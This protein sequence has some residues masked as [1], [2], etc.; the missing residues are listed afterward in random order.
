[1]KPLPPVLKSMNLLGF[2]YCYRSLGCEGDRVELRDLIPSKAV[3]ESMELQMSAERRW[4]D[5]WLLWA[6][7]G[8]KEATILQRRLNKDDCSAAQ[9]ERQQQVL[10]AQATAEALQIV[11]KRQN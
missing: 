6:M 11:L 1:M 9:A 8:V 3:Q 7:G 5:A 10:K 4:R 2:R